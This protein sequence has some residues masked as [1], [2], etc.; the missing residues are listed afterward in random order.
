MWNKLKKIFSST[1]FNIFLIVALAAAVIYFTMRKDGDAIMSVLSNV[2]IPMV[3]GMVC[4]MVLERLILGW[5][6]KLECNQ[7]YPKY[8]LLQGF[9]NAYTA[10]LFCNITP[11]A[12]GGQVAQGYIFR[13]QGIP[14]TSS[15]G[16]L[17][18][19]FIVYQ[20][21]MTVFV[22]VLIFY[23][24]GSLIPCILFHSVNN[25]LSVFEA[26]GTMDPKLEMALNVALIVVV[27]GGYLVYLIKTFS[28][29]R[30]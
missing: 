11:G 14:V 12:S 15:I 7:T 25:A 16:I 6:L 28:K 8:T 4:L 5:S 26:R 29:N 23:Y 21:T 22:L 10:G 13:K 3:I 9:V 2:S 30:E 18:L 20:A 24:S 27:L 19:D 17:W 1:A